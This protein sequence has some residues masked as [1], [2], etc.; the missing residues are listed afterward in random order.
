MPVS[1]PQAPGCATPRGRRRPRGNARDVAPPAFKS[2][3]AASAMST[4]GPELR[5]DVTSLELDL[6]LDDSAGPLTAKGSF[7][8]RGEKAGSRG[9]PVAAAC[10][11]RAAK[12]QAYGQA[13]RDSPWRPA[14][15]G[16]S[17][18]LPG[19]RSK[20]GSAS[21][22]PPRRQLGGWVGKPI[23]AG[24]DA[25]ALALSELG[26]GRQRPLLAC[27]SGGDAGRYVAQRLAGNRDQGGAAVR[28][29]HLEAFTARSRRLS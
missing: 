3:T 4:S 5:H 23:A 13:R 24:R 9:Q 6:A 11:A 21:S 10:S 17:R 28:Q 29:R 19:S 8:W 14:T 16:R 7:A 25:G 12:R 2:S 26:D 18:S 22:P 27:R 20:A 1:A 15:T